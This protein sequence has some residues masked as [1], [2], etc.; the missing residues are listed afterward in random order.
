M[1]GVQLQ[2]ERGSQR[3]PTDDAL[4]RRGGGTAASRSRC[5]RG[6]GAGDAVVGVGGESRQSGAA[7]LLRVRVELLFV[8]ES[9]FADDANVAFEHFAV[10]QLVL[11]QNGRVGENLVA[12]VALQIRRH[13]VTLHVLLQLGFRLRDAERFNGLMFTRF[14]MPPL[15][16]P[17]RFA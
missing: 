1:P 12:N 17:N 2:F 16:L 5:L 10:L 14:F 11:C 9:N 6:C 7:M 4:H 13:H 3:L 15:L 8:L